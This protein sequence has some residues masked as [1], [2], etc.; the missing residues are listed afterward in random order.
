MCCKELAPLSPR[1]WDFR[2]DIRMECQISNNEGVL[3]DT[4]TER[5]GHWNTSR[6]VWQFWFGVDRAISASAPR[7]VSISAL[8]LFPCRA[9]KISFLALATSKNPTQQTPSTLPPPPPSN[10]KRISMAKANAKSQAAAERKARCRKNHRRKVRAI[11]CR[12]PHFP[13]LTSSLP[14]QVYRSALARYSYNRS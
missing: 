13:P 5:D 3:P 14:H 9:H 10:S 2:Q 11:K 12:L 6:K 7:G 4:T 1:P 8:L